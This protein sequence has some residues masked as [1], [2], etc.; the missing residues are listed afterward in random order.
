M[1][2]IKLC[3]TGG[4]GF[5]G[6][7]AMNWALSKYETINFDIRPPKILEHQDHWKFVDIRDAQ[8]FTEALIEF[9]PTHILH[10]AAM[11]GMDIYEMSFFDANIK[12]VANL[13][14]ATQEL[15]CLQ[16]ILFT[17][18]LLVCPN[19]HIPS[20]DTEYDPPNLYGESKVIGEKLVRDS[21]M[22]CSWVIV[23]PT[24]IWGPWFEHSYKTFFRVVDRGW[25]VQPGQQP[26]IKP[27]S[28][29]GNTVH[30]MQHLL[31]HTDGQVDG[32]TYYLGDYPEHSI[33]EWANLIR[34]RIGRRG[35]TP[36]FPISILW[37]LASFGDLLKRMGWSDSPLTTFRLNNMLTGAHYPIKKMQ[38]VVG[39]LPY[40]AEE[41]VIQTLCWMFEKGLVRNKPVSLKQQPISQK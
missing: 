29:V 16:R 21:K 2:K 12:G 17:S 27:L 25:Y 34:K 24:S 36:V 39:D 14:R 7:T 10:L 15:S 1:N 31:L 37:V 38:A 19:G 13:I 33:Q 28:F 32:Q 6:T 4:S 3:V 18:S 30:M 5:I 40:S 23:R 8:S 11:T 26:I 35:K 41:G 22:P 9:Q 20:S